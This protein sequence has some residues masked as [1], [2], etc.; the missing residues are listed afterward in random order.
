MEGATRVLCARAWP[1]ADLPGVSVGRFHEHPQLLP[2]VVAV[3]ALR[4]PSRGAVL[5]SAGATAHVHV[6][7]EHSLG[8]LRCP[9]LL[10]GT[11][12][13]WGEVHVSIHVGLWNKLV[14]G[15]DLWANVQRHQRGWG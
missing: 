5:V 10:G 1:E 13:T 8:G 6:F 9:W 7:L 15:E 2:I 11:G 14:E 4:V 12:G 3:T